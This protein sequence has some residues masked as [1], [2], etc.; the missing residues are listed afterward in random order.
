MKTIIY[1]TQSYERPYF[2]AMNQK[3]HILDFTEESLSLDTLE[4]I[5]DHQALC[6]FVTD[7]LH[8]KIIERLKQKGIRLIALRSAGFDH[9]DLKA[10]Q[11]F[12]IMVVRVPAYSPHAVAE[13]T[14]G[15]MLA[16]I[17]KIPRTYD[18]VCAHNFS[19]EG[20]LGFNLQGKTVG[21]IGTGHIGS[22]VAKI[23]SAFDCHILA[24][25]IA[26]NN[27]CEKYKVTYVDQ[28]TLLQQSDIISLHCPLNAETKYL[29]NEK[30]LAL[31]KPQVV[32]INTGRGA[33]INTQAIIQA[34]KKGKIG[35]LALDVYEN[36]KPLF[37]Q[38]YS[39]KIILDDVFIRLQAFPN[40]LI[41]PH[42]AFF[43]QE[44]VENI[45]KI[46]LENLDYYEQGIIQNQ[47]E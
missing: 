41:T 8:R 19:L 11:D 22:I 12:G 16:L 9:I 24:Y 42:Q 1:S 43:T 45:I 2:E 15:L 28:Q 3:K 37:F 44:A 29:I 5:T 27:L 40:V 26:P 17:R 6:C 23:L 46:T 32:L 30:T 47:I 36:E 7:Q 35:A 38:N 20:Q 21:I 25:D 34:L 39:D 13:F 31:M 4:K 10:A 18:R 14:I 33:L